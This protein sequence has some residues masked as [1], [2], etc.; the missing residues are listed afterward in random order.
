MEFFHVWLS[1]AD[2]DVQISSVISLS[3]VCLR[4]GGRRE[5]GR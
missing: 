4:G 5:K 1:E 2:L 3:S